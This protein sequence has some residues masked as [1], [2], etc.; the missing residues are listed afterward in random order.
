VKRVA[1]GVRDG[2]GIAIPQATERQLVG[3]QINAA[4]VFEGTET[5]KNILARSASC[6]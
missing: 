6:P 4:F 3:N 1:D 5:S 2:I